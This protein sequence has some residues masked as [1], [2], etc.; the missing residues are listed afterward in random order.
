MQAPYEYAGQVRIPPAAMQPRMRRETFTKDAQNARQFESWMSDMPIPQGGELRDKA[1]VEAERL[2]A[3]DMQPLSSR[4]DKKDYR[5]SQPYVATGPNLALNPFFDRYDPTRDPRN[6]VREVR[7]AVF[8]EKVP[9][10][11]IEESRKLLE[12]NFNDRWIPE[13][14]AFEEMKRS[15][16]AFEILRPKID[17]FGLGYKPK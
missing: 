2:T 9:D 4:T 16:D 3:Y 15:F 13:T 14:T 8:E 6:M 1:R 17:D 11:G 7:A 10:R 5:Q 12:R